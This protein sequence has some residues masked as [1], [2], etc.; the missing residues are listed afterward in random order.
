MGMEP[1][2]RVI[3]LKMAYKRNCDIAKNVYCP[4]SLAPDK[5][6]RRRRSVFTYPGVGKACGDGRGTS[7]NFGAREGNA[8]GGGGRARVQGRTAADWLF[9]GAVS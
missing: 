1:R 3:D 7:K 2:R 6:T 4:R 5:A 8:P 9:P